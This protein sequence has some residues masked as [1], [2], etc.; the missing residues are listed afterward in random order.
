MRHPDR[1]LFSLLLSLVGGCGTPAPTDGG[2]ADYQ[3]RESVEQLQVTHAPPGETLLLLDAS[4]NQVATGVTDALGSYIFRKVAPGSGY[5]VRNMHILPV[6][7]SRKL[8]VMTVEESQPAQDFYSSQKLLPGSGYIKTRDGTQLSIYITMPGPPEMGPYPTVVNYSGYAPSKPG[9]PVGNYDFLCN[10][11]P[12]LCDAPNDPSGLIA[13]IFGYAT[14]SVNIRGTGCSGGAYDFFETLQLLDGYDVIETVAA[15]P[16]VQ[17]GKVGMTGLSYPG[18]TQLFVAS[19]QPPHLAAITPLSVIGNTATTL[20]PGGILN[21][22]F[23]LEWVTDVLDGADPYGQGWESDQVSKGDLVCEENQL[24]H[25]QKINNVAMAQDPAF[26]THAVIDPLNPTLLAP[27]INVPVFIAGSYQDEQTGPFFT[28]LLDQFKMSPLVRETVHNG[29]HPDGFAPEVLGEWKNFLDIEVA[30]KVPVTDPLVV[31]TAPLLFENIFKVSMKLPVDRFGPADG[32]PAAAKSKFEAEPSLR[33]I[34]ESGGGMP[35][36]APLGTF[37]KKYPSWPPSSQMAQRWY[38]HADGS[39]D[40]KAPTEASAASSFKLDPG[41]GTIGILKPN[42]DV[43]D[44]IPAYDW[45]PIMD[46]YATVFLSGPLPEDEVLAGTA[47]ADLWIRSTV[48]DADLQVN[49]SEVRPD[50]NEMYIQSGWLRASYRKLD[51]ATSTPLW[52]SPTY[53]GADATPLTPGEWTQ[54]RVPIPGFGH[55]F[56]AGSQIRVW[57]DTPG[58]TR[59]AWRFGNK[60]FKTDAIHS[61]GHDATHASSIALP[62]LMGESATSP[63]PPCPSLRGQQCRTHVPYTN[64]PAN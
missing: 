5:V 15:Q 60:T 36:G 45:P 4:G 26:Y 53:I 64:T 20:V 35:P 27:K 41:A 38:L 21:D 39:L 49:I 14:V 29:V 55:V 42:G 31:T 8:K 63:L 32:D 18:I 3:V 6:Q 52:P 25:G 23:A 40:P 28:T 34:F 7:D 44:P 61:I 56:R 58:R 17:F 10:K 62:L 30:H 47:S 50:G 43:W 57:I 13:G 16:W 33:M 37:E 12:T 9:M 2:N 54:V 51:S 19:T 22:G 59:A 1:L 48:D 24:L 11:I 46:G